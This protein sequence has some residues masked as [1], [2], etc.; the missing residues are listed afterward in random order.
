MTDP[1]KPDPIKQFREEAQAAP[2]SQHKRAGRSA[3]DDI[4]DVVGDLAPPKPQTG[5]PQCGSSEITT[6]RP[7][8]GAPRN[9]CNKCG[10]RW[11]GAPRSPA[12]LIL[13]KNGPSQTAVSGPYY[14]GKTP[15]P[16]VDKH[17]P[18]SRLKSKSLA[19]LKKK[20]E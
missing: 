7:L 5:C 19:A 20:G 2:S 13:A 11:L 6:T 12:K 17:S 15:L 8:G 1:D 10:H 16:K 18:K 9:T 3:A 14:R 4:I